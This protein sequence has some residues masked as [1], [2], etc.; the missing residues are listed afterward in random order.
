MND[1]RPSLR[2]GARVRR[3]SRHAC[4]LVVGLLAALLA[5]TVSRPG[6]AEEQDRSLPAV[7]DGPPTRYAPDV[8]HYRFR[9]A[10]DLADPA[11][12][13]VPRDP[14]TRDTYLR[15]IEAYD[16]AEIASRPDR[17]MDGP[18]VFMPVLVKYVQTGDER[19]ATACI[20]M[21]EAF[22]A[23]M[24]RQVAE[25]GWFWQFE[26]PPA[27]VPL[28]RTYLVRGGAMQ[29][30]ASWFRDL[31]LYYCRNVHVWDTKPI[32]W[33]GGC[34]RSMPEACAKGRAAA[35]YP[36]IPE[37][38]HWT[39][40]SELVFD[41]F[42]RVKDVG[43]NDAHYMMMPYF[44][45]AWAADQW[46]GD[47]RVFTDPGMKRLWD[48][49]MVEVSPDGAVVP[50]GPNAGW[51]AS[52]DSRV[53]MLERVAAASGDGRYR[54]VAHKLLNQLRYQSRSPDGN[55][56]RLDD[57]SAWLISLAW[58]FADDSVAPVPPDAGSL[59]NLR[60]ETARVSPE[61]KPLA[62]RLLGQVDPRPDHGQICCGWFLTGR[63]WP[64][65]LVLRS[66]W[67]A[68]DLFALVELHPTS[69]PA[70]PGGIMGLCRWGAPF[71]QIAASKGATVENR[72]LVE[73]LG[74]T[75]SR[76]L[77]PD[78]V[79]INEMWNGRPPDIR[80]EVTYFQDG[81]QATYASVRVSNL[82][83]L[84]V[85]YDRDFVFV[86]NGFL[87]CRETVTFEEA[88]S[89]RVAAIWNTHNVG[90][91]VGSHWA[92][93][94]I[95]APIDDNGNRSLKTPPAD[96]LVWFAP[97]EDRRLHVVDRLVSDP[98]TESCPTQVRHAWEGTPE[99]GRR[100]VFTQVYYPHP[101]YRSRTMSNDPGSVGGYADQLQ[102]SAHAAGITVLRDDEEASILRLEMQPGRI[103]WVV[104]NPDERPLNTGALATSE[105]MAYVPSG[106]SATQGDCAIMGNRACLGSRSLCGF[107]QDSERYE[108]RSSWRKDH[109]RDQASDCQTPGSL[110]EP[111]R[112][113]SPQ[114]HSSAYQ[115]HRHRDL[116]RH[117]RRG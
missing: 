102:A 86:K 85:V 40:Y 111:H 35:W 19:W 34:H 87:A 56:F 22:H 84:P 98:R 75:A 60:G 24:Q 5:A 70:N 74:G 103:E 49:L 1:V 65:K 78:P 115:L 116:R 107:K 58:L 83:G 31:W 97:R 30:D 20:A 2:A 55:S 89:A 10:C 68:G 6:A 112:P 108:L 7:V 43:Q 9:G 12:Y 46:T 39:R 71:T 51:N 8:E 14:V 80:S 95:D 27:L 88:F 11:F 33:R 93:T 92:N 117:L 16:P 69:F 110:C 63:E 113:A 61:N 17:G 4:S 105:R 29:P 37:A 79:R 18:R 32:E 54:F 82:D 100:M 81:P 90:P 73:D 57:G 38:A 53:A 114:D 101:P 96:L 64:D 15:C 45:L 59:W 28:Y 44:I 52:A 21:L 3:S 67:N 106:D 62:E 66:G 99:I 26:H 76:R 50:Y 41:D 94:F 23:A 36:D 48:R 77:H 109:A 104:F 13:P 42:W 47:D 91:Q 72:L 25:R